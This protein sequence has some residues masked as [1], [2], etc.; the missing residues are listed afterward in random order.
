MISLLFVAVNPALLGRIL[1]LQLQAVFGWDNN[2][3]HK[4]TIYKDTWPIE[5]YFQAPFE[6]AHPSPSH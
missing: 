6:Y 1:F 3:L 2:I 5:I 4:C